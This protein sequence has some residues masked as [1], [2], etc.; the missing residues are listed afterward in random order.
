MFRLRN[1][2]KRDIQVKKGDVGEEE[3][4]RREKHLALISIA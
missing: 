4:E 1:I 3:R 2:Q